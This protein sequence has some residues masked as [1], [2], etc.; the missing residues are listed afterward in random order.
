MP[1]VEGWEMDGLGIV[2]EHLHGMPCIVRQFGFEQIAGRIELVDLTFFAVVIRGR[3][4]K[5]HVGRQLR[6]L[7]QRPQ[8]I[9]AAHLRYMQI[10]QHQARLGNRRLIRRPA[11]GIHG[12]IPAVDHMQRIIQLMLFK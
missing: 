12:R 3:Q 5:H 7:A 6:V 8:E 10:Q 9:N 4:D 2:T 1:V 11:Q